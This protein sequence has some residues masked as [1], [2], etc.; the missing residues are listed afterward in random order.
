[1]STK[2]KK[3]IKPGVIDASDESF[4]EV[5]KLAPGKILNASTSL[6]TNG[7]YFRVSLEFT[8]AIQIT[9]ET[10]VNLTIVPLLPLRGK[11]K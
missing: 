11:K 1:M 4:R 2:A 3:R 6:F 9:L 10:T 7:E 8:P 5:Y